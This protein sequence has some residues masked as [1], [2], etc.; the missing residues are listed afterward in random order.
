MTTIISSFNRLALPSFSSVYAYSSPLGGL[1]LLFLT[2]LCVHGPICGMPPPTS[3]YQ[4]PAPA[5]RLAVP[6]GPIFPCMCSLLL[7]DLFS[8]VL[9]IGVLS[10]LT[11]RP[12]GL[13]LVGGRRSPAPLGPPPGSPGCFIRLSLALAGVLPP[14]GPSNVRAVP[15]RAVMPG[16]LAVA[17]GA[18]PVVGASVSTA[19][20]VA[21]LPSTALDVPICPLPTSL[22]SDRCSSPPSPSLGTA[23]GPPSPRLEGGT[24]PAE[25][26]LPGTPPARGTGLASGQPR[27]ECEVRREVTVAL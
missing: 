4:P 13:R 20:A 22:L 7:L 5:Q 24:S 19:R 25:A 23:T 15:C 27:H 16:P 14:P 10:R 3:P 17:G 6:G 11:L 9:S 26:G 12:A 21:C 18:S 8:M 2:K 1:R